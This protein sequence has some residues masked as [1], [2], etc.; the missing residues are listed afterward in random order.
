MP[1]LPCG[2]YSSLTH[3]GRFFAIFDKADNF[4]DSLF[5]FLLAMH[6]LKGVCFKRKEFAPKGSK[7]FPF[8]VD[9]F[10]EGRQSNFD[11]VVS[12]ESVSI[13]LK[14]H[15]VV[16]QPIDIM[17]LEIMFCII[18]NQFTATARKSIPML[19]VDLLN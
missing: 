15:N 13:H 3:H 16:L 5:A 18:L 7:F 2:I 12:P 14:E 17:I 9:P 10:S 6:V 1:V 19:S 4:C 11:R 8:R